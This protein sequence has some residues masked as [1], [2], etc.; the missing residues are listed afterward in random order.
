[1]ERSIVLPFFRIKY[2]THCSVW[3]PQL[4]AVCKSEYASKVS[5]VGGNL[6][7]QVT[8][9]RTPHFW[10]LVWL[11]G[12]RIYRNTDINLAFLPSVQ[13]IRRPG[14]LCRAW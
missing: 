12:I 6:W 11:W 9:E 3:S 13:V 5:W 8:K 7:E 1:M 14:Q 2:L 4:Y 10:A